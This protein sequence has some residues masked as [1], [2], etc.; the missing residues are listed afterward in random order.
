MIHYHG[1]PVGGVAQE[2]SRFFRGRHALVSF[3]RPDELPVIAEVCQSFVIDNG[4][5]SAWRRGDEYRVK[6]FFKFANAWFRHPSMDWC[7]VPD[8]I[9]ADEA[10]NNDLINEWMDCGASVSLSVPVW[11]M[12]ESIDRLFYLS[13]NWPRVAIG[14]S[15]QWPTPGTDS[16]WKRISDAMSAICDQEGRPVCRLHGLRMLNPEIFTR[17]PLSSADS[18]NAS[19]N[20]GSISRFGQYP[21]P[22]KAV[23]AAVIADRIEAYNSSPVWSA[24]HQLELDICG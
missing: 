2:A 22:S 14:S 8:T 9:D 7:L 6:D 10:K 20:S 11:H 4:A 13:S 23:R 12:H 21:A 18:A 24:S 17:L 19:V 1:S 15:G 16:W 5:F 3:A